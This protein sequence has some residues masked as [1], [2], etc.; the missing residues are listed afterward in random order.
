MSH[1]GSAFFSGLTLLETIGERVL[2]IRNFQLLSA[3][4]QL[5][6]KV[7]VALKKRTGTVLTSALAMSKLILTEIT[8]CIILNRFTFRDF[9]ISL[10]FII[11]QFLGFELS[12]NNLKVTVG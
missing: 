11:K 1:A 9:V 7:D 4:M 3:E 2:K 12:T 10:N 8:D 6:Q 5:S